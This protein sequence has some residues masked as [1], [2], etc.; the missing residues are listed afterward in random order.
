MAPQTPTGLSMSPLAFLVLSHCGACS[1]LQI[2]INNIA[3][4]S[5]G[6][7]LDIVPFH[8]GIIHSYDCPHAHLMP[9][10]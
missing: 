8:S 9:L 1:K 2:P 6:D 3:A 7:Q 10:A 5:F 4:C